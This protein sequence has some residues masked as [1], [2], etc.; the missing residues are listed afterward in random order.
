MKS[1][2]DATRTYNLIQRRESFVSYAL[3]NSEHYFCHLWTLHAGRVV[4]GSGYVGDSVINSLRWT[5]LMHQ[6]AHDSFRVA[7]MYAISVY[8]LTSKTRQGRQK[9]KLSV[10]PSRPTRLTKTKR[11]LNGSW[12]K[13]LIFS[14]LGIRI[15]LFPCLQSTD[16]QVILFSCCSIKALG[17]CTFLSKLV[18]KPVVM[19]S[20]MLK[21][22]GNLILF[23]DVT[24]G[25]R[26]SDG[27]FACTTPTVS[28]CVTTWL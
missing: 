20:K 13:F 6:V 11:M 7:G 14:P 17:W 3:F 27:R 1:W 8:R 16:V 18:W 2:K 22:L 26:L 23:G 4:A 25:I 24:G 5:W 21:Y 28:A 19:M 12:Q 15:Y 10:L 9:T